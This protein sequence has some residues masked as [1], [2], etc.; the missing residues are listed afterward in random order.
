MNF[1]DVEEIHIIGSAF[2]GSHIVNS[3]S[4]NMLDPGRLNFLIS[5][6]FGT[7]N[8]GAFNLFGLDYSA[9]RLGFE[10]GISKKLTAGIGRS[11]LGK[12]YDGYLKYRMITQ[13]EGSKN[14]PVSVVWFGSTAFSAV[15]VRQNKNASD[16]Y[17]FSNQ[18]VYTLQALISR[19][20]SGK[21][22]LQVNPTLIHR[23]ETEDNNSDNDI[24]SLGLGARFKLSRRMHLNADYYYTFNPDEGRE[25]YNPLAVGLDIVTGGHV[26]KVYLA[27]SAG[28]IE[29]EFV[30]NTTSDFFDG[31]IRLGFT[32]LR[33]FVIKRQVEG[34]KI[35]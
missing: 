11:S 5:H 22:S 7:L 29:K 31:D 24:F 21:F 20:F 16:N 19:E 17:R 3:Q 30:T 9:V 27:N 15:E 6:R 1:D 23:N 8:E 33:S 14:V 2:N 25:V 10:Y 34:G 35:H 12:N 18:L 26:F 32:V 4:T 28:M 13:T